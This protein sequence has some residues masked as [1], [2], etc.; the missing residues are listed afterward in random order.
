M[1]RGLAVF[2]IA[3]AIYSWWNPQPQVQAS[4]AWGMPLGFFGGLIGALYGTGGPFYVIYMSLRR[5]ESYAFRATFAA[6]FVFEG[7]FRIAGYA[8]VG[9]LDRQLWMVFLI[10]LPVTLVMLYLGSQVHTRLSRTMFQ[11][12]IS[13]LLLVSGAV[14][15]VKTL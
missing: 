9:M 10:S 8:G 14:L 13:G 5:L 3:Y 2:I 4:A 12:M 6:L 1:I 11:R 7:L 15:L